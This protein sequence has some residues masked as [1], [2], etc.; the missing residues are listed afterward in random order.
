M[1]NHVNWGRE[2][3]WGVN[4]SKH[5]F[6]RARHFVSGISHFPNAFFDDI[7]YQSK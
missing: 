2:E 1:I 7:G 5:N 6:F 3:R 4:T